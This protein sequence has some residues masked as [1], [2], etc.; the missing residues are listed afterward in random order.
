M[1]KG[2]T[3]AE[4]LITL[5][6]IGVIA[7]ITIP[8]LLQRYQENSTV[9]KVKK[10][11]TTFQSAYAQAVKENGPADEWTNN[12]G[13]LENSTIFYEKVFKPYFKIGIDCGGMVSSSK[14]YK[15]NAYNPRYYN[16][17]LS[18]GTSISLYA[19]Y[20]ADIPLLLYFDVNGIKEPN[21]NGKDIFGF[22][23]T[24]NTVL[25]FGMPQKYKIGDENITNHI[26]F[27]SCFSEERKGCTAWVIYKGN[28]DYLH[29]RDLSWTGKSKCS[30]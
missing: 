16:F 28:M 14:C 2:F 12:D 29:C 17:T 26:V 9:N 7:A 25:P 13:G 1:K 3:L 8:N 4:V 19:K 27:S 21:E 5:T 23:G 20:G 30:K 24:A 6:I 15:N 22:F 10:F 11:Y 18:D